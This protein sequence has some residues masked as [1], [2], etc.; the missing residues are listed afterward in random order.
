MAET[1]HISVL[2][3][4]PMFSALPAGALTSLAAAC[5]TRSV[6]KGQMIF[7]PCQAAEQFYVV[8]SGRVKIFK[9]SPRGDEQ[10]LHLYGPGETFGEAAMLAGIDFPAH[11]EAVEASR[12]LLVPRR[13]LRDAMAAN[14]DLAMGMLA[15][16][17]GK[18]R[19]FNRLIEDLSLKEVPARLA[20]V[21]LEM[22]E[23]AGSDA[24]TLPATKRQLAAQIGTVAET[25]SRALRKLKSDGLID[26]QGSKIRLLDVPALRVLAQE[27]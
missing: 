18:L 20:R 19:E 13:V 1:G 26:V 7:A 4:V 14:A 27:G 23:T 6:R 9:L 11:A 17:S 12:L 25:L 5:R 22:G 8:L 15:G 10:I 16:L 21:L 2:K 24:F 3:T